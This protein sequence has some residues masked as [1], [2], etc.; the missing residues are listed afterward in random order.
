MAGRATGCPARSLDHSPHIRTT[1][2][3]VRLHAARA[4]TTSAVHA[5]TATEVLELGVPEAV[6]DVFFSSDNH[7]FA[8]Q[9]FRIRKN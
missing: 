4:P 9:M 7:Y 8:S 2:P 1:R 5:G 3:A 6:F